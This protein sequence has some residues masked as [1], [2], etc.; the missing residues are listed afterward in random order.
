[1]PK[2]CF[3]KNGYIEAKLSSVYWLSMKCVEEASENLTID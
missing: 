3:E 2:G 1:M